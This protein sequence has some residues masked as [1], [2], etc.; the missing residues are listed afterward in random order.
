METL[1]ASYVCLQLLVLFLVLLIVDV[2]LR[3][4]VDQ[5]KQ[6]EQDKVDVGDL[7]ANEEVL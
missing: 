3:G 6:L 1:H 2:S 4:V 5:Q 7:V